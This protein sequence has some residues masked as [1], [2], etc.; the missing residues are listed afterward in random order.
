MASE[1]ERPPHKVLVSTSELRR[2]QPLGWVMSAYFLALLLIFVYLPADVVIPL[3]LFA[4]MFSS[5][6]VLTLFVVGTTRTTLI[7]G[8]CLGLV[9]TISI[10]ASTLLPEQTPFLSETACTVATIFVSYAVG[11]II[12]RISHERSVTIHTISAALAAYLLI[13]VLWGLIYTGIATLRPES[14]ASNTPDIVVSGLSAV[15]LF[16]GLLYYSFTT[17]T[18]LGVG[19]VHPVLPLARSATILEAVAGQVYLVVVVT[20]VVGI[21][22]GQRSSK[23]T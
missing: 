5:L 14:F 11:I 21:L 8:T 19:D 10:W 12:W 3:S 9:A 7:I 22:A 2:P 15:D 23:W 13:G 17:I 20:L 16:P 1:Q 6:F 18:T 4:A